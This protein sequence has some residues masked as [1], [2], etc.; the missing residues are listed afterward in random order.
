MS[1]LEHVR[2]KEGSKKSTSMHLLSLC[3][4][5]TTDV[6]GCFKFLWPGFHIML[7]VT[8][9]YQV[10]TVKSIFITSKKKL[11]KTTH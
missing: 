6:T 1:W 11:S 3:S 9:F 8:L 5:L 10:A 4:A 2:V 7:D